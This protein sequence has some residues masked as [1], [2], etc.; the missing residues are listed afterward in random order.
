MLRLKLN[1]KGYYKTSI[2]SKKIRMEEL[3]ETDPEAQ[4]LRQEHKS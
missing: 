2:S 3:Q 1:N 4:N